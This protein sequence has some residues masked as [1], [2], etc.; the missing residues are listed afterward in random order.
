MEQLECVRGEN[1]AKPWPSIVAFYQDLT[2]YGWGH[3]MLALTQHIISSGAAD[4]LFAYT[5][6]AT[7]KIGVYASRVANAEELI[8]DFDTQEKAFH[9]QYY[10]RPVLRE[11]PEFD[12]KYASE[13]INDKFDQFLRWIRW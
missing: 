1:R 4:R 9:F 7:L 5:S 8:I 13:V 3:E 6:H 11:Q 2:C 10:A 12:R